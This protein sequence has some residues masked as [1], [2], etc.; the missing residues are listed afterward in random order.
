MADL[1]DCALQMSI[2]ISTC[3][4]IVAPRRPSLAPLARS[5]SMGRRRLWIVRSG[6]VVPT[7]LRFGKEGVEQLFFHSFSL[8]LPSFFHFFFLFMPFVSGWLGL[9]KTS[10]KVAVGRSTIADASVVSETARPWM[11]Y[12]EY[13]LL[14]L[15]V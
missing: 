11:G 12:V 10:L 14:S 3:V 2:S 4:R 5:R 8:S 1:M 9:V 7:F 6:R 13:V 15:G